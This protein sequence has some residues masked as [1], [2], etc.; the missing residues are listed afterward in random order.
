MKDVHIAAGSIGV[1]LWPADIHWYRI[2]ILAVTSPETVRV[3]I[4]FV[5]FEIYLQN[6]GKKK[7]KKKKPFLFLFH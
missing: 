1:A 5:F 7:I 3:R 4:T 2:K 6:S